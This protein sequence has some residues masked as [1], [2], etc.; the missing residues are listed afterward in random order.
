[1]SGVYLEVNII[2]N[3]KMDIITELNQT[4]TYIEE[5]LKEE[6]SVEK[7]AS[8]TSYSAYHYQRIFNYVTGIPLSEYIRKRRL[9]E[10]VLDLSHGEKVIDVAIKYGYESPDSFGRAFTKQHGISPSQCKNQEISMELYP[11]M[12]FFLKV[13][14]KNSLTCKIE[15]KNAMNLFGVTTT[16]DK[17]EETFHVESF[18]KECKQN[19]NYDLMNS[20]YGYSKDT[21]LQRAIKKQTNGQYQFLLFQY[22]KDGYYVPDHFERIHI[23]AGLWARFHAQNE[24]I[25]ELYERIVKEWLPWSDYELKDEYIMELYYDSR[26]GNSVR[27]E[28]M[29]PL[30]KKENTNYIVEQ[31]KRCNRKIKENDMDQTFHIKKFIYEDRYNAPLEELYEKVTQRYPQGIYWSYDPRSREGSNVFL[32]MGEDDKLIGKGHAMI[33]E[34]QDDDAPGYAEHRIFIHYRVLPEYEENT[35]ILDLLYH[36][37]YDCALELRKQLSN[38]VCQLCIGNMDFEELYNNHIEQKG[39]PEYGSLYHFHAP[40]VKNADF[41]QT[42]GNVSIKKFDLKDPNFLRQIEIND[43]ICFRT[44]ISP[45]DNY[46]ELSEGNYLAVGAFITNPD[47]SETL[48]GSVIVDYDHMETPEIAG[49]MVLPEYRN[50]QLASNMIQY[51][52]NELA[53]NGYSSTWLVTYCDN[54]PAKSLYKKNGFAIYGYEKRYMKYI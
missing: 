24:T 18:I 29:I 6:I 53:C 15:Q 42:I 32:C 41:T 37:V 4:I 16:V 23:N 34:K 27:Y 28:I 25:S 22:L 14:G 36:A 2:E 3:M 26:K 44:S 48:V 49:V 13:K 9:S 33:Y 52:L 46:V 21:V 30:Q 45:T 40:T 7:L 31:S 43:Q 38:R 47:N 54:I 10:A 50:K 1:M 8:L 20:I 51:V 39:F 19:G 11:K 35:E 12:E 5:H 17:E